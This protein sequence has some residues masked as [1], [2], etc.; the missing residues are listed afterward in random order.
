MIVRTWNGATRSED[1]EAYVAVLERTGVRECRALAGNRGVLV[2]RRV[3]GDRCEFRFV[4]FWDSWA[5][6]ESF[7]GSTPERAVFYPEDERYL[8]ARDLHVDHYEV[9]ARDVPEGAFA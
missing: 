9:A 3:V 5:A 1:A 2:L 4:S 7:A 8:V 6:V